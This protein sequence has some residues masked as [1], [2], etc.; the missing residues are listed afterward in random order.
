MRLLLASKSEARR[1]MLA[2]AG[3]AFET[4]DAELDE[5]A[6]KGGLEA[7]GFDARGVAEELA[8]LKAL[9]VEALPGDLVIGADQTLELEDGSML[10]KPSSRA[11]AKEQLRILSGRTHML[12]SA[13]VVVEDG[14]TRWWQSETVELSMRPLGDAFLESYLD[15]EYEAIRWSVGGYRIEGPGVQLFERIEGS[16]F[17]VLGLPLLP[18]LAYFRERGLL[19]S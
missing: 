19:A 17:A 2:A 9:S 12:H 5:A 7:A 3:I 15:Q 16:H 13:A 1:Q 18:L 14:E 10:S 6:A 8:Q 4:V 11:E